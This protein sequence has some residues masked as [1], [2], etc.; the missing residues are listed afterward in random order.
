[1]SLVGYSDSDLAGDRD[2]S[3]STS[4]LIFFLGG[5]PVSWQSQKQKVVALS[6]CEAEYM[7]A[8]TASCHGLWLSRLV[9]DLLN[10]EIAPPVL[11]I[12]NK[13][14]IAHAKNPGQFDRCKHI[15]TRYHF[16]HDCVNNG[17]LRVDYVGT[18]D[19]LADML[20]KALSRDRLQELR[21]RC[22]VINTQ[23]G[24]VGKTDKPA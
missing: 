9:A 2:D 19:Q 14:A 7:A 4:G 22:S 6:S 17:S 5:S 13:S 18:T 20:T 8:S 21:V 10:Q 12:D 24:S 16:L 3:K 23:A 1:M 11:L 15:E